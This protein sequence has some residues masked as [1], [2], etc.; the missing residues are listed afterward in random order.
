MIEYTTKTVS[1]DIFTRAKATAVYALVFL[2][3]AITMLV[4]VGSDPSIHA[5]QLERD[6]HIQNTFMAEGRRYYCAPWGEVAP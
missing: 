3:G 2:L 5:V 6:C 4:W 1:E